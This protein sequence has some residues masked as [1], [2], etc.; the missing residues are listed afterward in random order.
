MLFEF[1]GKKPR[2]GS[3]CFVA[4]SAEIIGDVIIG[5]WSYVGPGAK[6]LGDFGR[7]RIGSETAIEENVVIHARPNKECVIGNRVTVGHSSVLH[8]CVIEDNAV[9]GMGSVVSDFS[10][11]GEW[12]AVGEGA[13]VVSGTSIP[14]RKVAVG[15]P[16]KPIKDISEEWK[17]LWTTYKATA[18]ETVKKFNSTLKEV[19]LEK[20]RAKRK[21]RE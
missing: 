7:V 13:V 11:V 9:I 21:R 8:D 16:A 15:I 2:V 20:S 17:A 10:T 4:S 6:I 14:P 3:G 1:D 12:A 18:Q 19:R 5:D